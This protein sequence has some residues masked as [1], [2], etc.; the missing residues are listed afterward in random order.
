[1]KTNILYLLLLSSILLGCSK[2]NLYFGHKITPKDI[3]GTNKKDFKLNTA[4]QYPEVK[5]PIPQDSI[6]N[7]LGKIYSIQNPY[8]P[9]SFLLS[10]NDLDSANLLDSI[11]YLYYKRCGITK[12]RKQFGLNKYLDT[13]SSLLSDQP[14]S[15]NIKKFKV[16]INSKGYEKY[17]VALKET[18]YGIFYGTQLDYS[19]SLRTNFKSDIKLV[20]DTLKVNGNELSSNLKD[21]IVNDAVKS[22]KSNLLFFQVE[23]ND[24]YIRDVKLQIEEFRNRLQTKSKDYRKLNI[25]KTDVFYRDLLDFLS[26]QNSLGIISYAYVLSTSR[27]SATIKDRVHD[28]ALTLKAKYNIELNASIQASISEK[29]SRYRHIE[30]DI[31]YKTIYY[32]I[33]YGITNKL[34]ISFKAQKK[35]FRLLCS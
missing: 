14:T 9:T 13:I 1:M 3:F 28:L 19:D 6:F 4:D 29:L 7:I 30:K 34:E 18:R 35:I 27:K 15:V 5:I 12:I 33:G 26:D 10:E 22:F 16:K 17:N 20:L 23:L 31:D 8:Q 32:V 21:S 24:E 11:N 2:N 25:Y